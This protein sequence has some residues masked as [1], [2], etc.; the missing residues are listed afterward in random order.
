MAKVTGMPVFVKK[1]AQ[2]MN[3]IRAIEEFD[4]FSRI[5]GKSM[6]QWEKWRA[7]E[8][9][10]WNLDKSILGKGAVADGKAD[11]ECQGRYGGSGSV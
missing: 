7:K 2:Y 11:H 4:Y 10:K 6:E 1:G 5:T 9:G 3:V 8:V